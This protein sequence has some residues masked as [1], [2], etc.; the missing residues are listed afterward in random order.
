MVLCALATLAVCL[1]VTANRTDIA[2]AESSRISVLII[3][4]GSERQVNTNRTTVSAILS[5]AGIK[6][7]SK[8]L[9]SPKLDVQVGHGS[10][11]RV[12]RVVEKVIVDKKQIEFTTRRQP[13]NTLRLGLEKVISQGEPG[14]KH[15]YYKVKYV[16]GAEKNRELIRTEVAVEPKDRVVMIGGK[17]G[18]VSRGSFVSR[19]II[20]MQATAYDPGPKS[21]GKWATGKTC[22]GLKAGYGVVAVDPKVIPLRTNL[23]IEGYGYAV[24]GDTGSAIKGNR[25][26]LGFDTYEAAKRFGRQ[27]VRVH[28]LQ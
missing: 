11:I 15:L 2:E 3:S 16:D 10:N 18:N 21:C 25:I 13:S 17:G 19:R 22:I 5:E 26:D 23:F 6:I 7:G 14:T 27:Q 24:A 4:D 1:A 12:E 20:T 9:V 28:V 8:D